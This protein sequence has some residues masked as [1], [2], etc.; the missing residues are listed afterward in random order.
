M[1]ALVR[2]TLH[3]PQ[4]LLAYTPICVVLLAAVSPLDHMLFAPPDAP[5]ETF[6]EVSPINLFSIFADHR[7]ESAHALPGH[8]S[9]TAF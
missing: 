6:T 9:S 5:Q 3:V 4:L 2:S 8:T 1:S 7:V